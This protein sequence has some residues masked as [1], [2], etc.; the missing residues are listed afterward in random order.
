MAKVTQLTKEEIE[1]KKDEFKAKVSESKK[2]A[3]LGRSSPAKDFLNEISDIVK[4][5]LK[6]N[7]SY[8]QIAK[9]IFDTYKFKISEQTLRAFAQNVL[10]V[11]KQKRSKNTTKA[12]AS[13]EDKVLY[14]ENTSGRINADINEL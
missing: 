1:A 14:N 3:L 4:D 6:Y 10:G 11:E 7:V 8:K 2:N 9:D 13:V 12:T 5:A